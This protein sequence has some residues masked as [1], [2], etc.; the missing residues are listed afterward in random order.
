MTAEEVRLQKHRVMTEAAEDVEGEG[1]DRAS[2][3]VEQLLAD[4]RD[5][6]TGSLEDVGAEAGKYYSVNFPMND[7]INDVTY[8]MAFKPVMTRIV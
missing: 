8:E 4:I 5:P 7:G 3:E 1:P 6:A 2:R